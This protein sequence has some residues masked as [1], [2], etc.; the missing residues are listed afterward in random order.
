[1]AEETKKV[2]KKKLM[3]E[4]IEAEYYSVMNSNGEEH[5]AAVGIIIGVCF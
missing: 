3:R 5:D 4:A 1:M 2:K